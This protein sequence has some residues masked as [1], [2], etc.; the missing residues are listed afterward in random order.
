MPGRK[1]QQAW[2]D[3]KFLCSGDTIE[4]LAA[5]C[6]NDGARMRDRFVSPPALPAWLSEQDLDVL[7]AEFQRSG[8]A[9]GLSY[10]HCVGASWRHLEAVAGRPLTVPS[11]FIGGQYD[12]ATIW[13]R[14]AIAR[15]GEYL[16]DLRG[17]PILQGCGHWI[18]QERATE[19][20]RLLL[21]F[22]G[23]LK[24]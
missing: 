20:N 4:A 23:T 13:G 11:M 9:G 19:T 6:E 17:T 22:L 7:S 1:K 15:A 14:D 21:D 2:I 5:D 3:A 10:Y 16:K 24:A 18:Q 8:F 12:V